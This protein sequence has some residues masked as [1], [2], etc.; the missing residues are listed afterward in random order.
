MIRSRVSTIPGMSA[1]RA[2]ATPI[3]SEQ[4]FELQRKRAG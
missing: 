1:Q 4:P 3:D 2:P